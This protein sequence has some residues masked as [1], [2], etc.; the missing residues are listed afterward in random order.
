MK[1]QAL[2]DTARALMADGRG[3]LAIDES[4]GTCDRRLADAGVLPTAQTRLAWRDLLI[5]T[6][7]LGEYISG[8]IL[9]DET[10]RQ[11]RGDGTPFV[12]VLSDA[13]IVAG[14]KV[15]T[16]AKDLA[17]HAGET[18]TEGLDGLRGRLQEYH[19]LGARFAKWRAMF[20][21]AEAGDERPSASGIAANAQALARYAAL[22]QE[23]GLLPIVEPEVLME[24]GH[25]LARCAEVTEHVLRQVFEQLAVQRVVPE[26]VI[27]KPNMVTRGAAC[28]GTDDVDE[29]AD[30]TVQT[31]RR[32]APACL[33]GIAFLSGG[34]TGAQACARLNAMHLLRH[35]TAAALP[36]PLAFSFA[37]AL[38]HPALETWGGQDANREAA[39]RALLHRA[40]CACAALRGP[41]G[42]GSPMTPRAL[43]R[44]RRRPAGPA[45]GHEVRQ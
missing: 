24:G 2:L 33:S 14:I 13:G 21:I 29:V 28:A 12:R 18:I 41:G 37:R 7:G 25:D 20:A 8:A 10:I 38:Q 26:A 22:C 23:A 45:V 36:W 30:A 32:A 11:Q 42:D 1:L 31:L 34:Q 4:T 27:L 17:A 19:A 35:R 15:D 16:G 43:P 3:L 5:G 44:A 39:Q 40:R 6:P 9:Y